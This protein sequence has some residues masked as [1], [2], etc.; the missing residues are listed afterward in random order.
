MVFAALDPGN[1]IVVI[2]PNGA[3]TIV[4]DASDGLARPTATAV[5]GK[6]AVHHQW[7]ILRTP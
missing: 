5:H 7:S 2:Y 6:P 1:Q 3:K 4:L